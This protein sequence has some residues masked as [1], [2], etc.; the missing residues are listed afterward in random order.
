M[1]ASNSP[2]SGRVFY[3]ARSLETFCAQNGI[4]LC[5]TNCISGKNKAGQ[6]SRFP[7]PFTSPMFTGSFPSSPLLYSPDLG[8]LRAG[9][10]DLVPPLSLDGSQP[11][12]T[13]FSPPDSP[14]KCRQL[15][16]P[17]LSLYDKLR[18]SPQVGVVHL[19][20]QNDT[21]G[22][23]L[24]F[25]FLHLLLPHTGYRPLPLCMVAYDYAFHY[26]PKLDIIMQ[27]AE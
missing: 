23:I 18:S 17:V 21:S 24:R 3:H 4:R 16:L 11:G 9:R 27:L 26:F 22:S 25:I 15:S 12:K 6:G 20:L 10:I 8:P 5:I 7:T 14:T 19:A 13:T 1:E 2:D